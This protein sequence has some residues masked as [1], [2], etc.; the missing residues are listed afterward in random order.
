M[1]QRGAQV[2]ASQCDLTGIDHLAVQNPDGSRVIVITN[3]GDEQQ[4]RCLVDSESQTLTLPA[5]SVTT[6]VL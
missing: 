4:I 1:I 5:G 6:L 3:Q 2:I